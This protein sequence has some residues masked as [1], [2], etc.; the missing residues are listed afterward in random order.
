M[1]VPIKNVNTSEWKNYNNEWV[2]EWYFTNIGKVKLKYSAFTQNLIIEGRIINLIT[3]S[4]YLNFDDFEEDQATIKKFYDKANKLI[5]HKFLN[6]SFDISKMK[7]TQIEYSFNINTEHVNQYIEFLNLIYH[8]NKAKV[9]SRYTNYTE[10]QLNKFSGSFY[11]KTNGD[12]KKNYLKN[13]SIDIYNKGEQLESKRNNNLSEFHKSKI[14]CEEIKEASNILRIECKAG[15]AYLRK[16]SSDLKIEPTLG[17]LLNKEISKQAII[18][19][20]KR[21]FTDGD[22][23]SKRAVEKIV[24]ANNIKIDL[25]KPFSELSEYKARKRKRLLSELGVCPYYFLP[26]A[27]GID[28][29]DNP[30]KLI[31]KKKLIV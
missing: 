18:H 17:N 14:T 28:R 24:E 21:F 9:F 1:H 22:F 15:Y 25:D 4:Y 27:F 8:Q 29:L 19:Q 5:A 23:Y 11:L 31:L 12:Y 2:Q 20:L 3:K 7:V 13:F 16:I 30:I 6:C 10:C 26:E